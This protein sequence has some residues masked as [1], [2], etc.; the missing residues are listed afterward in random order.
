MMILITQYEQGLVL[1]RTTQ[2]LLDSTVVMVSMILITQY[3]VRTFII[4]IRKD[5][6]KSQLWF[7]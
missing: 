5:E 1:D 3:A 2:E 6:V 4:C 7:T